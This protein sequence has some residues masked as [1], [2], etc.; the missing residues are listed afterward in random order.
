V[1][2]ESEFA[3][4]AR[5]ARQGDLLLAFRA[6]YARMAHSPHKPDAPAKDLAAGALAGASG[7]CGRPLYLG[8]R[9]PSMNRST[10]VIVTSRDPALSRAGK[11]SCSGRIV[12]FCGIVRDGWE[13]M[14]FGLGNTSK[15]M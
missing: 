9:Y 3:P 14:T 11:I 7:W 5:L 6:T 15:V 4:A 13:E 10:A 2:I 12:G 8:V 1:T